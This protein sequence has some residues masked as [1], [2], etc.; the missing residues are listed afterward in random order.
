MISKEDEFGGY[1]DGGT[2][3][4]EK[5]GEAE[6]KAGEGKTNEELMYPNAGKADEEKT[7][8]TKTAEEKAAADKLAEGK[9][10]EKLAAEKK[11]ADEKAAEGKTEEEKAAEKKAEEDKIKE[12]KEAKDAGLATTE[13]LQFPEGI[14][15]NEDIKTELVDIVNDTEKTS[16]EKAQALIGLQQKLYTAQVEAHEEQVV[17]W[18]KE[19]GENK[20]I[21]GDT[22]DKMD[23]NL[24]IAKKGFEALKI[25]GLMPWLK[26]TGNGSNPMFITMGLRIG[27]SISEDS[28]RTGGLGGKT[29]P[30]STKEVFY[31]PSKE[32]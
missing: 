12:A 13:A 4:E 2:V 19:A 25:E 21:I 31:G 11:A 1:Y 10:D 7:A 30:K 16:A 20:E 17:A 3:T 22:G 28:F 18:E 15:I 8:E 26:A 9:T 32:V 5:T 27:K 29:E 24:A 23:E 14:P 6:N